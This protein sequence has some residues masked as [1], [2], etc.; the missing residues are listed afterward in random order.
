[1]A[2][3]EPVVDESCWNW[4]PDTYDD[5]SLV[6]VCN[7]SGTARRQIAWEH[8]RNGG[9][10]P[11]D[12][13]YAEQL[14]AHDRAM[15]TRL[16]LANWGGEFLPPMEPGEIEIARVELLSTTGDVYSLR[17]GTGPRGIRYRVVDENDGDFILPFDRSDEPLTVRELVQLLE[18]TR[19]AGYDEPGL[20]RPF[21]VQ[22]IECGD[23]PEESVLFASVRSVLYEPHVTRIYEHFAADFVRTRRG[24]RSG[25]DHKPPTV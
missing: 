20:V 23:E 12:F 21:W 15:W 25:M 3:R 10:P 22:Q 7:I 2:T 11:P 4:R 5:P 9:P 14:E 1:M 17:A 13:V 18:E 8:F 16:S 24:R 6:K 19:F